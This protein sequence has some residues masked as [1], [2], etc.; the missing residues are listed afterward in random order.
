MFC[1]TISP[2][3]ICKRILNNDF[4]FSIGNLQLIQIYL[5][6]TKHGNYGRI[7]L[8]LWRMTEEMK[9]AAEISGDVVGH[10]IFH[11]YIMK[12]KDEKEKD[13]IF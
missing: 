7:T 3:F 8:N 10:E 11:F 6:D 2:S 4:P 5:S 13:Y 9:Q 12:W 1:K